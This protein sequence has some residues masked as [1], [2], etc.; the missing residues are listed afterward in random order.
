MSISSEQFRE[1]QSRTERA[2]FHGQTFGS[3]APVARLRNERRESEIQNEIEAYLESLGRTCKAIRSRM[4]KPTTLPIG[5]PDFL[6]MHRGRFFA[7]EVKRPGGKA[8]GEQ[9]AQLMLWKLA[10]ATV[11]VVYSVDDVREVMGL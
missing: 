4:D 10:G 7:L 9:P 2:L 5:T 6:I 8:S 1:M 11:G 3:G